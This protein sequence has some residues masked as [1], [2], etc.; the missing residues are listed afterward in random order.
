MCCSYMYVPFGVT[1][2]TLIPKY[3]RLIHPTVV[4][5]KTSSILHDPT[6]VLSETSSIQHDP[7]VVLSET[8]SILHDLPPSTHSFLL[9]I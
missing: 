4:L 1:V 7:T 5:S 6:V 9:Q 8:S 3:V 2:Y